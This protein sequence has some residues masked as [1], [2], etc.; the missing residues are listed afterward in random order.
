MVSEHA[1]SQLYST[2]GVIL[3]LH[4]QQHIAHLTVE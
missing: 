3:R 2:C 1:F 4:T